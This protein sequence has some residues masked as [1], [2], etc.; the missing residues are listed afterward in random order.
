[1]HASIPTVYFLSLVFFPIFLSFL[2]GFFV[3]SFIFYSFFFYF[4]RPPF[5]IHGYP[6]LYHLPLWDLPFLS[7]NRFWLLMG[8]PLG[9][10]TSLPVAQLVPL[11][12][13]CW[14]Y[15]SPFLDKITCLISYLSLFLFYSC[16]KGLS[17]LITCLYGMYQVVLTHT[18]IF[19]M[20]CHLSRTIP[21]KKLEWET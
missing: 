2:F 21:P 15:H 8:I 1:M 10:L 12:K 17:C 6:F 20:K 5:T 13:V 3:Y 16:G 19:W 7:L 18:Y 11:L 9:L 14:L 4:L